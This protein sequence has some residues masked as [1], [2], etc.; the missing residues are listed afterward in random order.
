MSNLT[1]AMVG[2]ATVD[3]T[4]SLDHFPDEESE[5]PVREQTTSI[6]GLMGRAAVTA[7]R[8]G[9]EPKLFATCGVGLMA[10]ALRA[11]LVE[12]GVKVTWREYPTVSQ[13]SVILSAIDAA[14]RTTLWRPQPYVDPSIRPMLRD[15][16]E[17]VDIVLLDATDPV[18]S[19]EAVAACRQM[20][21]ISILDTGSGRPW[22]AALLPEIDIVIA[23]A[24]FGR[25]ISGLTGPAALADLWT[26]GCK[27]VFAVTEGAAGGGWTDGP[28]LGD[29]HRW[30]AVDVDAVDTCGAG[31]V[32]HGA[33]A[34]GLAEGL[35]VRDSIERAALVAAVSTT[36]VGNAAIRRP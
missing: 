22:T 24:K 11:G 25:K 12:E 31:D 6:G 15:F 8:L 34:C 27:S 10:D 13:H 3:L 4:Y 5:N 21:I 1:L 23:S 20:D 36:E 17:G 18:L 14:S 30:N 32:F 7:A 2:M 26:K 29:A 16:L 9:C 19:A 35:S 28:T 33:F